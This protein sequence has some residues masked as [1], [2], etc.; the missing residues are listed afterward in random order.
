MRLR[1][2]ANMS[3]WHHIPFVALVSFVVTKASVESTKSAKRHEG[4]KGPD[5]NVRP[6]L[7]C[8]SR[9]HVVQNRPMHVREAAVDAVVADGEAFVVDT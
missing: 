7:S 3:R 6:T 5:R 8:A 9:D 2:F 1:G 4:R